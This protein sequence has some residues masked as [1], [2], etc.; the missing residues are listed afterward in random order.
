MLVLVRPIGH[1]LFVAIW[2][3][4]I[5][6]FPSLPRRPKTAK[7]V[8]VE[9]RDEHRDK[10]ME[11]IPRLVCNM[12]VNSVGDGPEIQETDGVQPR[13]LGPE[14]LTFAVSTGEVDLE[15]SATKYYLGQREVVDFWCEERHLEDN[16]DT[17]GILAS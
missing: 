1:S 9:H 3:I 8:G 15:A 17:Q 12:L 13:S 16:Q 4:T 2:L 14:T 7:I 6:E 11:E 10:Y 5:D